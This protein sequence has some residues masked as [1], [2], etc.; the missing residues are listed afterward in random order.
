M[1]HVELLKQEI[2][3]SLQEG[4]EWAPMLEVHA[5][6]GEALAEAEDDVEDER[7]ISDDLTQIA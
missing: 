7:M 2:G 3:P 6:G 4:G 5:D 1:S